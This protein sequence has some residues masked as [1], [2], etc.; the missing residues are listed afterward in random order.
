MTIAAFVT[1]TALLVPGSVGLD[2]NALFKSCE[3]S[4]TGGKYKQETFR[5]RLF[6]PRLMRP[7]ERYPLLIWLH[8]M[9]GEGSDN[10]IQLG[11]FQVML[12]DAAYAEKCKCFILAAQC[13]VEDPTW[14]HGDH[15]DN[16]STDEADDMLT[17]MAAIIRKTMS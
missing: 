8:G 10:Y 9:Q 5:Y 16:S 12:K 11:F 2:L 1:A 14:F 4:Y 13:P 7:K 17:V 3:I 6:M 15:A